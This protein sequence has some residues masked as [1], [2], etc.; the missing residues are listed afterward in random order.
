VVTQVVRG[1]PLLGPDEVLE[2][3]R[4]LDEEDR[5][6]VAGARRPGL[7][8][9]PDRLAE[10]SSEGRLAELASAL[11]RVSVDQKLAA[12]TDGR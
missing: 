5:R 3:H 9:D 8:E 2:L 12:E 1:Q 4:V 7:P 6:V 10:L 11:V